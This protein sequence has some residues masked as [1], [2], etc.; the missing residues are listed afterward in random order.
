AVAKAIPE[1]AI[2][3]M[4][5]MK[6]KGKSSRQRTGNMVVAKFRHEMSRAKDPQLHTHAVVL[7]MTQRL[8]GKWRA[9]SNEDIFRA[10]EAVDA[11]YKSELAK[12][13]QRLGY[14]IRLVDDKGNFELSHISRSQIE[15]FSSR[16]AVIEEALAIEGKT[17]A[18][19]NSFEKQ[20]MSLAT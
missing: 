9:L 3:T 15:A 8:D 2:L 6:G 20:I 13:L 5:R 4:A 16:S 12:E 19:A 10:Y 17:G 11:I 7:N 14:S 18:T 1:A